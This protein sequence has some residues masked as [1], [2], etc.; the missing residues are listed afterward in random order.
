LDSQNK[1][2]SLNNH[3]RAFF[4]LQKVEQDFL[5]NFSR[6]VEYHHI[7]SETVFKA[8][9]N[10]QNFFAWIRA[11]YEYD[12]QEDL[13]SKKG[14]M[15]GLVNAFSSFDVPIVLASMFESPIEFLLYSALMVTM[16]SYL[17]RYVFLMPQVWVCQKKY[18]L[19]IAVML[20]TDHLTTPE[21]K[22]I[23]GIECDGYFDH[24]S[25]LNQIS[26]SNERI[27]R[28]QQEMSIFVFH[29][30]GSEI[31]HNSTDL[32]LQVWKYVEENFATIFVK[33]KE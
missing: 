17:D 22:I 13:T 12:F 21:G 8:E 2:Q 31:Y 27:Q 25:T 20:R 7:S 11:F 18:R 10:I 3:S 30:S 6:I 19:D 4:E 32:A 28:I 26:Q 15:I 16:P 24:S 33:K 9:A 23:V 1:R 14:I 29:F 5:Q